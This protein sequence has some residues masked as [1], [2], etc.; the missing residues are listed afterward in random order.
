MEKYHYPDNLNAQPIFLVWIP[1]DLMVIGISALT[2][3][4]IWLTTGLLIPF[5]FTAVYAFFTVRTGDIFVYQ[6]MIRLFK[7]AV[8]DQLIFYWEEGSR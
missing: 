8:S 1:R 6:Y 5:L 3:F 7:F 4:V 2:S